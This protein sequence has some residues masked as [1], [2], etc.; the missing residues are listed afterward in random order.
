MMM[1]MM[2]K[3]LAFQPLVAN[4]WTDGPCEP[5]PEIHRFESK[6]PRA[7]AHIELSATEPP[8]ARSGLV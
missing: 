3:T 4:R 6:R 8:A 5:L 7:R 1:M 2:M